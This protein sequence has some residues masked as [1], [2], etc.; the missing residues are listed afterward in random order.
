VLP[1]HLPPLRD[2]KEDIPL[3]VDHFIQKY[4]LL[5][6]L[7]LRGVSE[8]SL[9]RLL[10]YPWPGNVRELENAVERSMILTLGEK[11]EPDSLPSEVLGERAPWKKE[12]WGE[13]LSI[14]K[15]SRVME[16]ELIRRALKKTKGNRTQ[17]A[18]LLEISHPALLSK[19]KEFGINGSDL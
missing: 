7:N 10:E 5:H 8:A 1:L 12:I 17:A 4:N 3:L 15:A 18:R 6:R 19:I 9:A 13:D 14:K 16:E 2:R 11:I